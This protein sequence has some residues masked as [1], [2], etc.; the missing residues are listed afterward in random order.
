M[1]IIATIFPILAVSAVGFLTARKNILN[2]IECDALSKFVFTFLIPALLFIGTV[3]AK[4]PENMEWE[5]LFSYYS[6]VLF[7]YLVGVVLSKV[8]FNCGSHEQ[9]VFG[10]GAAYSNATIVGIPIC[11]YVLGERSLL[12]LFIII[13]VHNLALFVV[14]VFIAERGSLSISSFFQST[15]KILKDLA[16]SPITGSLMLGGVINIFNIPLIKPLDDSITLLSEAAVPAALFVLG[17]SLNKYKMRGNISP[18]LVIVALKMLLLPLLVWFLV[19]NVFSVDPLWA[20]TALLTA[21]M[22]IGIS[23]YVF[24]QKYQKYE[25]PIATG[26]VLSTVLSVVTLA[27][28]SAYVKSVL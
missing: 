10:M 6:A 17:A 9:S 12:P 21:A 28:I 2:R 14:G 23:V 25:A 26:I 5:F 11:I 1:E 4:I 27:V 3:K 19:F 13:S 22:P 15:L 7:V 18:A 20:S 8:L 24:S 16:L